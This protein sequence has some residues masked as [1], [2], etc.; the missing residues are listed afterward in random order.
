[1]RPALATGLLAL[2]LGI[3]A[4][5]F[6][7]EQLWVPTVALALVALAASVWIW[8]GAGGVQVRRT[9]G[10]RRVMED[11]PVSILLEVRAGGLP[12]PPAQLV[13]PLLPHSAPLRTGA[14]RARVRIEARFARRGRPPLALPRAL[15]GD[16]RG[17]ARRGAG[18]LPPP[19][20]VG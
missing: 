7:A 14:R 19:G 8:G 5:L 20:E 11:E 9:L 4:A 15:I 1:M 18:A 2:A 12:L 13:D 17:P 3:A 6:D 10:V 16:P